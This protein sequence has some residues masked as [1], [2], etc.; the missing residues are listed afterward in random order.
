MKEVTSRWMRIWKNILLYALIV[1]AGI[2]TLGFLW[3]YWDWRHDTMLRDENESRKLTAVKA[4]EPWLHFWRGVLLFI[5]GLPT[6]GYTWILMAHL[7]EP[8]FTGLRN[9]YK[10]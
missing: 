9:K 3:V 2:P 5:A 7:E 4:L 1:V 8:F 10:S 6:L